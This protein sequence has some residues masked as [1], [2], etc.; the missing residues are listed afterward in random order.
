MNALQQFLQSASNEAAGTISGPVDLIGMGLRKLGVPVPRNALMSS[1][2]MKQNG[3]MQDVPQNAAS[4]A[5]QTFGLLSPVAAAAKAPQIARGLL[6]MGENAAAPKN[7]SRG[8]SAGQRGIFMGDLSKTWDKSAAQK[9]L[10]MEK[11][12]ADP[13]AIWQ[14]TGTF[15]GVDGK[16][17]QEIDDS[18]AKL[19]EYNYT[20]QEAFRNAMQNA[21]VG[22]GDHLAALSMRPYSGMTKTQLTDEY[23]RTGGEIVDAALSGDMAKAKQLAADRGGL[24]AIFGAMR[25]R[26]YGP[27]SSYLKHGELGNAYPD[28]YRLHT[29]IADDMVGNRGEYVAGDRS[30]GE[31]MR[32]AEKPR[33]DENK[34]TMLH[35]MQHAIQQRQG[36]AKGGNPES[37]KQQ[38]VAEKARDLLNWQREIRSKLEQSPGLSREAAEKSLIDE[39]NNVG[40]PEG[41]PSEEVR[42]MALNPYKYFDSD[43]EEF[44]KTYGLDKQVTPRSPNDVYRRLAGEAEARAV[45]KRMNMNP[46]QRRETFPLDSYDVPINELIV[47]R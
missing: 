8:A 29:R 21:S 13:R 6:T 40:W 32:L 28:V 18:A 19:R 10:E 22:D 47:R 4:L 9:A 44:V 36:F 1:E 43:P 14:E 26:T 42:Q 15:K 3:L 11:A 41:V 7:V 2:W 31:Q 20:P 12:G 27:A 39:Y 46:L 34:S 25:D 17:R 38:G 37:Y 23:S 30:I 45:Q 35:E 33:W 5:G 16:W 24:D